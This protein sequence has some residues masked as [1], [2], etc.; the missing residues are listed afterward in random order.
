[1]D[2]APE[3]CIASKLGLEELQI[4]GIEEVQHIQTGL[5]LGGAGRASR[6]GFGP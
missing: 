3:I 2:H 5:L 1:L 4:F 6:A